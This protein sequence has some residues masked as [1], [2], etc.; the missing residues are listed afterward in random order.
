LPGDYAQALALLLQVAPEFP[1]FDGMVFSD[2]AALYGLHDWDRTLPAL[3]AFT[4]FISAE[5]AIRPFI[6]MDHQR[7]LPF[8]YELA[9]DPDP[10]VRRLASEGSRPRL[11]WAEALPAFKVDPSPILPILE[12][13]KADPSEDVR[14]SVANNLN[15]IAKDNP[16]IVLEIAERWYGESAEV[17][18]VVKHACRTLLKAG[19]KRAMRLF[20]FADP[21]QVQVTKLTFQPAELSIGDDLVFD[22]ELNV[23]TAE[24]RLLRLEYA[25]NF[26][27]LKGKSSRK[28]FFHRETEFAPGLH[29]ISKKHSFRDL[30]TRT[31]YPGDHLFEIIVNGVVKAR[32]SVKLL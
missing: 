20:G 19:D 15:D 16:Q 27:R 13:L 21:A 24:P 8:L 5:F 3:R 18:W 9:G 11:P 2:Y 28:V 14:R 30:S 12:K 1:G 4:C 23:Q 7:I 17:D 32:G 10:A 6:N 22:Y 25:V 29:T 31:H 26:V